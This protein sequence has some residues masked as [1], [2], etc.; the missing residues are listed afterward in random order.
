MLPTKKLRWFIA[1]AA[2]LWGGLSAAKAD[3]LVVLISIDGFPASLWRRADAPTPN[4]KAL[5]TAG[6]AADAMTVSNPS[7]TWPNHTT[8]VTGV[9]PR[10][11][12]VLYNGLLV[13]RGP[14]LAPTVDAGATK[15]QLVHAPTIYDLAHAAGLTTGEANWVAVID[16]PTIDWQFPE[17][18]RGSEPVV[19]EMLRTGRLTPEELKGLERGQPTNLP[20]HDGIWLRGALHILEA[21]RP[22]L[23]LYHILTTDSTHHNHGPGNVA[24]FAALAFADRLVGELVRKVAET[25]RLAETT[26]IVSTDHGFKKVDRFAY[27]NV[28][29]RKA[30]LLS[31][32][33]PRIER[34]D[35]VVRGGG[36][37][38]LVYITDP[39]RRAELK[40]RVRELL[41]ASEGIAEVIDGEEAPALGMPR[42]DE[43]PAAGDFII[44]PRE[45]YAIRDFAA[46]EDAGGPALNYGGTHGAKASD[47][48]LDGIFI[49]S[50]RGIKPGVKLERVC[51]L[52]VA[53]TIARLLGLAM[54]EVE[55]RVLEE[56][57][58]TSDVR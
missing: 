54:P 10:R 4:L 1:C 12:G 28:T 22:N 34:A 48:D 27:P 26:F 42:P 37:V 13:R 51:N 36:G 18:P 16:A 24:S 11:H 21:H 53:P 2:A 33:G 50:G 44:Y 38:A 8:L 5:A 49:A 52:D 29:L 14:G 32:T 17:F 19:Q 7:I 40:P 43:N 3:R 58:A 6:A 35:A 20:W 55:G 45:G 56:I 15:E 30:G 57:L 39:A 46:G 23:L 31:T 41:E 25:G 47:P 9:S